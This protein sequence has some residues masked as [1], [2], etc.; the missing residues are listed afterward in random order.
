MAILSTA[1]K[2]FE[3]AIRI[4][5]SFSVLLLTGCNRKEEA[6][7]TAS[8]DFNRLAPEQVNNTQNQIPASEAS[9]MMPHTLLD[10]LVF[11]VKRPEAVPARI[12]Q[13][14]A[15]TWPIWKMP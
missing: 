3:P 6:A 9:A 12:H 5:F 15:Y 1:K 14:C 10:A 11:G 13:E 2:V 7:Q 8:M 4:V